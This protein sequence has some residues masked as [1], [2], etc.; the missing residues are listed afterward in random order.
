MAKLTPFIDERRD[1]GQRVPPES[2]GA[3]PTGWAPE[4]VPS[5]RTSQ[6]RLKQSR[7]LD[8]LVL[9]EATALHVPFCLTNTSVQT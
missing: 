6:I 1:S 7:Y 2:D 8:T 3:Q 4:E 9:C 5:T